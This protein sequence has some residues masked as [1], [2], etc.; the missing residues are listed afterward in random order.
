MTLA[1][2][3]I[4]GRLTGVDAAR[5]NF[6]H[7]AAIECKMSAEPELPGQHDLLLLEVHRKNTDHDPR[8]QYF[9]LESCGSTRAIWLR[10]QESI[11][12]PKSGSEP[13]RF[14]QDN[15]AGAIAKMLT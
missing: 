5:N 8:V 15:G 3:S 9:A 14:G 11:K 2:G 13:L 7:I 1:A 12:A 6:D 10:Y 4:L